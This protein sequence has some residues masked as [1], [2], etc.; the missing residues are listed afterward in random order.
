M[1]RAGEGIAD[2]GYVWPALGV[3]PR[4]GAAYDVR[5][6]KTFVAARRRSASSSIGPT[7][8]PCSA[9]WRTRR[10]RPARR[11]NG[12]G[13]PISTRAAYTFGPVPDGPGLRLRLEAAVRRPVERPA[14][15]SRCRGRR[16]STSATS[17]TTPST[18]SAASRRTGAVDLNTID[19][20]TTLRAAGRTR[21]SR[22]ARRCRTTCCAPI[23]ATATSWSSGAASTGRSTRSR[24]RSRAG[25]AAACQPAATWIYTISDRG[26]T[27]LPGPRLRLDHADGGYAV[28]ADQADAEALFA[29]Q[30][31]LRHL[32]MA[33]AVWTPPARRADAAPRAHRL[34]AAKLAGVRHLPRSTPARPTTSP[35]PIRPVAAARSPDRPTIRRGS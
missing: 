30:G 5:G 21:R 17:G 24:R 26:N 9:R 4:F 20:G 22:P 23:A 1:L 31:V 12:A 28:R 7:A 19:L 8:T 32:L 10:W 35:T 15:S 29:D 25:G 3:A 33:N 2:T 27:G 6:D 13:W 11:S 16:R 34:A 14:C 18:C